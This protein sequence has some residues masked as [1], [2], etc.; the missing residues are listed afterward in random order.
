MEDAKS[1][2]K[3]S[4]IEKLSSNEFRVVSEKRQTLATYDSQVK[5]VN[6]LKRIVLGSK[7]RIK[8]ASDKVIDLSKIHDYSYSATVR[9]LRQIDAA[10]CMSFMKIFKKIFDGKLQVEEYEEDAVP[11]IIDEALRELSRVEDVTIK[12]LEKE[13]HLHLGNINRF[14]E[15]MPGLFRGSAPSPNDLRLLKDK[16]GIA[17]VVS[18]DLDAGKKIE[19]PCKLLNIKQVMLPMSP[20]NLGM[21]DKFAKLDLDKLLLHEGPTFVHCLHGK[22]RTGFL[23][24]LMRAKKGATFKEAMED[25]IRLDFGTGID[26]AM[27]KKLIDLIRGACKPSVDDNH[28]NDIVHNEDLYGSTINPVE[29]PSFSPYTY[30]TAPQE[31]YEDEDMYPTRQDIDTGTIRTFPTDSFLGKDEEAPF[32][33][34]KEKVNK[35]PQVG[36]VDSYTMLNGYGPVGGLGI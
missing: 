2:L 36:T 20:D 7:N 9:E 34:G 33:D 13:A 26:P 3:F 35:A 28:V 4:Y 32:G 15:A 23:I 30:N 29:L 1:F 22:D 12:T 16:F 25:A 31:P 24:A 10:L 6:H 14:E 11:D 19:R 5:A 8:T 21:A 17:K 27:R 18:L